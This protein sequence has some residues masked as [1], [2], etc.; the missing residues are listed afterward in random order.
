MNFEQCAWLSRLAFGGSALALTVSVYSG[1]Q[2]AMPGKEPLAKTEQASER[3]GGFM[4]D[5][6]PVVPPAETTAKETAEAKDSS[7]AAADKTA[8][9]VAAPTKPAVKEVK[10][11]PATIEPLEVKRLVVTTAIE[12]REPV[13]VTSFTANAGAVYAFIELANPDS[14]EQ[15][16]VVTFEHESG[17]RVG[18]IELSVPA[19]SSRW[20][21]WGRTGQIKKP[22]KWTA[23]ISDKSGQELSRQDFEVGAETIASGS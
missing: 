17:K 20:R 22:G 5:K 14:T 2:D 9:V 3:S 6:L 18:F 19:D 21:T 1:C 13:E 15:G 23:V 16:I 8:E 11:L 4:P 10:D 12:K 7:S